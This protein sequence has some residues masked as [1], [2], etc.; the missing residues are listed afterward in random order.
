[1]GLSEEEERIQS[2]A[3]KPA[4]EVGAEGSTLRETVKDTSKLR[5]RSTSLCAPTPATPSAGSPCRCWHLLGTTQPRMTVKYSERQG[6]SKTPGL[7]HT[8]SLP[9]G[10]QVPR[11]P[12][13]ETMTCTTDRGAGG[14]ELPGEEA[15]SKWHL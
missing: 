11:R 15:W 10:A 7:S 5:S 8:G 12:A 1:M 13:R 14:L 4:A 6:S 9:L 2:T 3:T